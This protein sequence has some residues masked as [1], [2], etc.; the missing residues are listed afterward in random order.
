MFNKVKT[1]LT[2][3]YTV[4][5][6]LFLFLFIGI[7]YLIISHQIDEKEVEQ[8]SAYFKH[9]QHEFY[10]DLYEKQQHEV[11]FEPNRS[12]FYYV[13][14]AKNE[15]VSGEE[16][17]K[18]FL[19]AIREKPQKISND[20]PFTIEWKQNHFLFT[21]QPLAKEGFVLLGTDITDEKHLVENITWT[22]FALTI[23]FSLIFA[24]LGYNFAGQAMK[25]IK[26]AFE[27]QEKFVSDASHELRTPLSI[28][29]SSVDLLMRE[30]KQ[31]LSLFG[32]EVLEDVKTEAQLMNKLV[33]DLLTLARSDKG[34]L[35]MDMKQVYLSDLLTSI[36]QRFSRKVPENISFEQRIHPGIYLTCDET[37]IQ[38]LVYILLDNA[39]RF[40]QKGNVVISLVPANNEKVLMVEDTG[41]G[42]AADDL[43]FI[44]DRFYR[45][46]KVREKGGAGLGLSIAQSIVKAHG[47][48]IEAK[49]ALGKGS[50]FTVA[51]K[52]TR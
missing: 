50:I 6:V 42:I 35:K 9:E 52:E 16:T 46:D 19:G 41:V 39:I 17:K 44:F 26:S 31:H 15:L 4:S 33:N 24:L 40:T 1:K 14:N 29:Y 22:L 43:P 7:L 49:S 48:R 8:L 3:I 11:E 20:E 2:L 18:G 51:F 36:Y 37:R 25:P 47:G 34:Q 13:Y 5:L 32:Q 23:A 27:Q 21:K 10:E 38:E 12:I 45:A 28:F 30:E